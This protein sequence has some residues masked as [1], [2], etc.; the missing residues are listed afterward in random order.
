[1]SVVILVLE[2]CII[3]LSYTRRWRPSI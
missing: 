3:K 1:M 2:L